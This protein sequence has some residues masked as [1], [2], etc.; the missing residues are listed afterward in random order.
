M[1]QENH[2][3]TEEQEKAFLS[4]VRAINRAKKKGLVFYGK[5][6]SLVAFTDVASKY[7]FNSPGYCLSNP[8]ENGLIPHLSGCG[9]LN[10]SGADDDAYYNS[11]EDSEKFDNV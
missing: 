7:M 1:K 4:V 8:W 9:L 2:N 10:D 11:I 5:Q 3:P 6:T